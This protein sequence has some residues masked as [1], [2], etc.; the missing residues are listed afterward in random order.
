MRRFSPIL[1]YLIWELDN[2]VFK[3]NPAKI[4][5]IP[6]EPKEEGVLAVYFGDDDCYGVYTYIDDEIYMDLKY[7][8]QIPYELPLEEIIQKLKRY[9]ELPLCSE[10]ALLRGIAAHEVRHRVQW[11]LHITPI[12]PEK[13][14]N[15]TDPILVNIIKINFLFLM[16]LKDVAPTDYTRLMAAYEDSSEL[17]AAIIRQFVSFAWDRVDLNKLE[18]TKKIASLIKMDGE[19]LLKS[20]LIKVEEGKISLIFYCISSNFG[21]V[22]PFCP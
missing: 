16:I 19:T 22:N 6:G 2:E 4:G 12:Q 13:I 1:G 14:T 18:K 8:R 21:N 9:E 11:K 7:V 17:D 20:K 5:R 15:H 10:E 3:E